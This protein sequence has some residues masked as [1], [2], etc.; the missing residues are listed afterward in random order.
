MRLARNTATQSGPAG[1][2]A[3]RR[4]AVEEERETLFCHGSA[5]QGF[6]PLPADPV[7]GCDLQTR[8][9]EFEPSLL[10]SFPAVDGVSTIVVGTPEATGKTP[11]GWT[12]TLL[13]EHFHQL[14]TSRPGYYNGVA[15]LDLANGD[16]T[17]MWMLNYPFPYDRP[18]TGEAFAQLTT[19]LETA[20]D[21]RDADAFD[22]A[23]GVYFEARNALRE[24]V[25]DAD[26]R[27]FEFQLWQEGVARW[28]EIAISAA[29]GDDNSV[30]AEHADNLRAAMRNSLE[31]TREQGFKVWKRSA[32]YPLGAGEA[33]VLEK[34]R[35]DWRARYFAEPFALGAYF[36][37]A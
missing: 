7:T 8:E 12:V 19:A 13:H 17:G 9:R 29:A 25:S 28:T 26:W 3:F 31:A 18:E 30:F 16:E 6:S 35:P 34:A 24:T 11:F 37:G 20:L 2:S 33:M 10:A 23:F 4:V 5:A 32:L 1:P 22:V 15:A 14:Q 27:Y 36:E 21:A